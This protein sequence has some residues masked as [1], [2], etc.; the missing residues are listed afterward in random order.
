[1]TTA[2]S[3]PQPQPSVTGYPIQ[4]KGALS[5]AV[6]HGA[7]AAM[8]RLGDPY[9]WIQLADPGELNR[10]VLPLLLALLDGTQ[11]TANAL[12]ENSWNSFQPLDRQLGAD[13]IKQCE[14]IIAQIDCATHATVPER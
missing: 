2:V 6:L 11:S 14:Q 8:D 13:L 3:D 9:R 7:R 5:D 10:P 1:M 4:C 12:S